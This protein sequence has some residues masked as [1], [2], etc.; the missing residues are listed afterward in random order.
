M[1][2]ST[3]PLEDF[4]LYTIKLDLTNM[5]LKISQPHLIT[6]MTQ[7]FNKYVKSLMNFNTPATP[8]KVIVRDQETDI[9]ISKNLQKIYRSGV[10]SL[11]YLINHSRP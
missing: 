11:L 4:L 10:G 5:T 6:T 1:T 2:Q 7:L 8:H 3:V 9:K